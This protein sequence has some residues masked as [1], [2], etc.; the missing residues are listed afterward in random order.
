VIEVSEG[1]PLVAT[2]LDLTSLDQRIFFPAI[3]MDLVHGKVEMRLEKGLNP[4]VCDH[5]V[6][7]Y[8]RVD[9]ISSALSAQAYTLQVE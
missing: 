3:P 2:H 4:W 6:G 1:A 5:K 9:E 8:I 7:S